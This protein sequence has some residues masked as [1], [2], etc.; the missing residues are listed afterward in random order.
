MSEFSNVYIFRS[1]NFGYFGYED[2][3]SE[4]QK[5]QKEEEQ[6]QASE[7]AEAPGM[8]HAS[9]SE[10]KGEPG[11]SEGAEIEVSKISFTLMSGFTGRSVFSP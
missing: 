6:A 3:M 5:K 7:A 8:L 4:E 11:Q 2:E 9:N 1:G 10:A